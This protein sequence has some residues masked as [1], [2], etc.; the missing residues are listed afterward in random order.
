[1]SILPVFTPPPT[2]TPAPDFTVTFEY[3][4]GC[5]GWDPGFKVVN[6]GGVT[7]KSGNVKVK[8]TVTATTV[9]SS[10]DVF[11]KRNGCIVA[12]AIPTVPPGDSGWIYGNSFLYDPTGNA[13]EATITLCTQ[14]GLA[15][16][17]ISKSIN[18]TP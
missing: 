9:N 5:V 14:P 13:M 1:M 10:T 7:F 18:F 17:C 8:D 16:S 3:M 11:D 12:Q 6:T 15:G 4:E 2:P